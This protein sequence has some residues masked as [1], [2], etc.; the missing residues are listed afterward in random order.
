MVQES[1]IQT[2]AR[3]TRRHSSCRAVSPFEFAAVGPQAA[4]I[5]PSRTA[6]TENNSIPLNSENRTSNFAVT[7]RR[8]TTRAPLY[9]ENCFRRKF[10]G[11]WY[12][13]C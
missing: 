5:L 12:L 4:V 10:R 7:R 11:G 9:L 13:A 3:R 6:I 2:R 8:L 1:T